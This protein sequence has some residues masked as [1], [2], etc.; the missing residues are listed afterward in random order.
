MK[1]QTTAQMITIDTLGEGFALATD[2]AGPDKVCTHGKAYGFAFSTG[3]LSL[4]V[5]LPQGHVTLQLTATPQLAEAVALA[6]E[7]AARWDAEHGIG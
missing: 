4:S 2:G 5:E 7:G 1:N 3:T 6:A